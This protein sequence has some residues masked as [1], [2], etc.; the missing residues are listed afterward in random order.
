MPRDEDCLVDG[1]RWP[2]PGRRWILQASPGL[3]PD[4]YSLYLCADE[5]HA[6]ALALRCI[7][8]GATEVHVSY[9]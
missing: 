6:E 4:R 9:L 8:A 5:S 1:A 7:D 2:R 3:G